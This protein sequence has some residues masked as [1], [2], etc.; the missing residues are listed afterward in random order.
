M[1]YEC[2]KCKDSS[3]ILKLDTKTGAMS[4]ERCDCL[5]EYIK[6]RQTAKLKMPSEF[7]GITI[8]DFK[9]NV[10]KKDSRYMLDV[11]NAISRYLNGFE[12]YKSEGKGIYFHS[13]TKGSGK[14]FLMAII[15]NELVN[16]G[17]SVRF[18]KT[19][20]I[21]AMIKNTYSQTTEISEEAVLNQIINI[22][23]LLVDDIGTERANDWV[24]EKFNYIIDKR[25]ISKKVTIF[26]SNCE[27]KDLKLDSRIVNRINK[28]A[29]PIKFPEISIRTEMSTSENKEM[30]NELFKED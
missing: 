2:D 24:N 1:T 26:T 22:D 18:A 21:L 23:V 28:M 7:E 29:L 20:D 4:Q 17:Y 10:Y 25:M 16:K 27:A 13:E 6:K 3:W 14:T 11:K 30:L 8:D 9:T 19:Y 15:G 12:K 5:E